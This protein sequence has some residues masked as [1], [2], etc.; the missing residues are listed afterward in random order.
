MLAL[1][2]PGAQ[3]R[4]AGVDLIFQGRFRPEADLPQ[5]ADSLKN[6]SESKFRLNRNP[7]RPVCD[8]V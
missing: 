3:R 5:T 4:D 7:H 6:G 8:P 1:V 2:M